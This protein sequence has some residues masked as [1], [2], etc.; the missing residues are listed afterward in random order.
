MKQHIQRAGT[1]RWLA[2]AIL[3]TMALKPLAAQN[4][5]VWEGERQHQFRTAR[6]DSVTF[7]ETSTVDIV[8]EAS[9]ERLETILDRRSPA[10]Q[11]YEYVNG[12]NALGTNIT[13][14]P[15]PIPNPQSPIPN[16]QKNF[17]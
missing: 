13:V 3:L 7:T 1:W 15:D 12:G 10:W 16:P 17:Y 9:A 4:M 6:V 14:S 5:I 8:D 11:P 2:S